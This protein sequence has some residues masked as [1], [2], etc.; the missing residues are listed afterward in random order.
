MQNPKSH[1]LWQAFV[2][3]EREHDPDALKYEDSWA[4]DW[5]LFIAGAHA[6]IELYKIPAEAVGGVGK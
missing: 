2:K 4:E 1:P 3:F 5:Q 6:L